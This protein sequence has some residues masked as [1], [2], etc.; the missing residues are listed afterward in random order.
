MKLSELVAYRNY[1]NDNSAVLVGKL[2]DREMGEIVEAVK[3]NNIQLD[4]FAEQIIAQQKTIQE[5]FVQFENLLM[6]LKQQISVLIAQQESAWFLESYRLYDVEMCH[7]TPEYIL[8]RHSSISPQ[9]RNTLDS[10]LANYADWQHA[11]MVIRPALETFVYNMVSF[12]PLYIIDENY[13][14]LQ[15]TLDKFPA[16][17]QRRLRPYVINERQTDPILAKVPDGQFGMCL[18][19]HLFNFRPLEVIERYLIE[20]YQK[21]KPGGILIMTFNDCDREKAVLLVEKHFACYTPGYL[22]K[23]L[24]KSIGYEILY[25]WNDDGPSTWL[26]LRKPGTLTTLKGGQSFAKVVAYPN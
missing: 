9:V 20:I 2:A 11:G 22:L 21:L 24:V 17:Y 7:E 10:R 23:G 25:S 4:N 5:N 13:E 8:R 15:P 3:T 16:Q 1:L 14:L 18:V 26:E 6:Q 12:D 19:Y